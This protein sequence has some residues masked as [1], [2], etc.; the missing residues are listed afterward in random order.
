MKMKSRLDRNVLLTVQALV[1]GLPLF[2]GGRQPL[3]AA[4]SSLAVLGLLGLTLRERR[5]R[6]APHVPG[7]AA[8]AVFVGLALL[9]T[10]PLP[11][12]FLRLLS[13]ATAQ[14]YASVLPGWPGGGGWSV[15]RPLAID[16]Y[17]VW[18]E[19]GR[20]AIGLGVFAV[21]V[22]YPW[23]DERSGTRKAVFARLVLTLLVGGAVLA[24]IGLLDQIAGNGNVMW[25]TEEPSVAGRASGPFVNPNHFAAWLEM[26]I[27][28][29]LAYTF[30]L[31]RRLQRRVMRS[32]DMG[33]GMGVQRRRAWV[34]ALVLH[35]QRLWAPL[36]AATVMLLMGVA[37]RGTGSRGGMAALLVGLGVA[38]A[39]ILSQRSSRGGA[40]RL[41]RCLPVALA[42][43][44]VVAAAGSLVVWGAASDET[45]SASADMDVS[46]ATRLAVGAQGSAV[47]RDHPLFGTGLGSWLHAF[48]PYVEPPIVGGIWDHAHDD[49]LELV[50]DT[51]LAGAATV[52]VFA[53]AVAAA[54]R[55]TRAGNTDERALRRRTDGPPGFEKPDW[56]AALDD[57][58]S[59]RWGLAGGVAAILVHSAVDFSLR[60]PANLLLLMLILA[61]L[62]LTG[63]PQPARPAPA[64]AVL[65]ALFMLALVPRVANTALNAGGWSPIAPRDCFEVAE[66]MLDEDESDG[67]RD[68]ALALLHH[69]L[70]WSP[71]DRELHEQLAEALGPGP[72]GEQ[73]LRRALALEPWAIEV[74]DQ[75]ALRLLAR[76]EHAAGAAE[77][78]EAMYRFPYLVSHAYLSPDLESDAHEPSQIVRA[79]IEG[80][81]LAVRLMSLD[82]EQSGAIERGL[83]RALDD[84]AMGDERAGIVADLVSV[85]EARESW[86]DAA[87]VLAA[88]A[89]RSLEG[90]S[91]L[92]HAARNYLKAG[93]Y[94]AAE[95]A[96][97]AAMVR[98]PEQGE[99]YR[100]LAVEIY[101]ERGDFPMAENV[102]EAGERNA[103]DMLPV[104]QGVIQVLARRETARP[105]D[106][107][108]PS[109]PQDVQQEEVP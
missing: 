62:V 73:S 78:E 90:G 64:L 19:L 41:R 80:D 65:V 56:H 23:G 28:A 57:V 74:R 31:L 16:P 63:P 102:L 99:L 68:Q 95:K 22:G 25:I 109:L 45:Q 48:R 79:L 1:L 20:L 92:A 10:L 5:R 89:G 59:L 86:K 93:E 34:A 33:R 97:L 67:A 81:T 108:V 66:T 96:L 24:A 17:G 100:D 27:P 38:G 70:D 82:P 83:R 53:L 29:A 98:E 54:I 88:E 49:Y 6:S 55:G 13:P 61:L 42:L 72:D 43:G 105:D 8:L 11:P 85:L 107:M 84:H 91:N 44:L 2:L 26:L 58:P 7:A 69:A 87:S 14:L 75:L 35:Q 94:A 52:L 15:W 21:V 103:L 46:L 39:G 60:M 106:A 101:A 36:V 18:M 12:A 76:G 37:H 51:G 77:L 104:Y 40:S 71:A 4:M 9:T 3:A 30:T 47:V 32:V 50:A